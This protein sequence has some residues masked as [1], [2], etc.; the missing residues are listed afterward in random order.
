MRF[1]YE[2]KNDE[3]NAGD[4]S[5]LLT[6]AY[7]FH[8]AQSFHFYYVLSIILIGQLKINSCEIIIIML[9]HGHFGSQ[10]E[11]K[12]MNGEWHTLCFCDYKWTS[13]RFCRSIFMVYKL[14]NKMS[15]KRARKNIEEF[16][17]RWPIS[18][19]HFILT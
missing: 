6:F 7:H 8:C 16:Y 4:S 5:A 9:I 18:T 11:Q 3:E 2:K 12:K 15:R 10:K 1:F 19:T 14:W 17:I 13:I